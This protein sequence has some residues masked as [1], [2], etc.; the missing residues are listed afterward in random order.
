MAVANDAIDEIKRLIVSGRFGPGDKLPTE[1]EL[2]AQLGLSR[3]S[4]RE[5][6]RALI[7]MGV[8]SVRQGDGTY[9]TSLEPR[10]LLRS[11]GFVVD[12]LQGGGSLLEL[13]EVRRMLEPA[14]AALAAPRISAEDLGRL[15]KCMLRMDSVSS[16]EDLVEADDEFHS[17]LAAAGGNAT[18]ASLVK[19]LSGRTLRA[20]IW[21]G[22]D[23][24]GALEVTRRGHHAIFQAVESGNPELARAATT[25]HVAE[26]E[27]WFRSKLEQE[28]GVAQTIDGGAA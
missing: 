12:L 20:R 23:D 28:N 19:S 7:L 24:G 27:L 4:L 15:R 3:S 11:T 21:R 26:V 2:A 8:L 9:V 14:A 25:A 22:L 18:L 13:L 10:L 16:V 5:A 1:Q 6:V 17:V